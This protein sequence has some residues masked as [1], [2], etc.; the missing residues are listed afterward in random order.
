MLQAIVDSRSCF[1]SQ[2]LVVIVQS[3]NY[4]AAQNQCPALTLLP[5]AATNQLRLQRI[6]KIG[7]ASRS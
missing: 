3:K 2:L 5:I 1:A 4:R 7:L 6:S